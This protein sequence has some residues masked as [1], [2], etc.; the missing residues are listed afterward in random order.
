M[1]LIYD[2]AKKKTMRDLMLQPRRTAEHRQLL[3]T[4]DMDRVCVRCLHLQQLLLI[5]RCQP[6][7]AIKDSQCGELMIWYMWKGVLDGAPAL[8]ASAASQQPGPAVFIHQGDSEQVP[9]E[10]ALPFPARETNLNKPAV[11]LSC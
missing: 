4:V 3:H 1:N 5:E 10:T 7:P 11:L 8:G 9:D 6:V 2:A